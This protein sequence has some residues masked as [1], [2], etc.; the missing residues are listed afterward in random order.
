MREGQAAQ[1]RAD[2]EDRQGHSVF[3]KTDRVERSFSSLAS[4]FPARDASTALSS[5]RFRTSARSRA[6][7]SRSDAIRSA[8]R[9]VAARSRSTRSRS[10][11]DKAIASP[12]WEGVTLIPDEVTLAANGQIKVTAVMLYAVKILRAAGFWKQQSQ[13]A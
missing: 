8:A 7:F 11:R 13:H 3:D 1:G 4:S 5:F 2:A 6:L 9:T 12:I 10:H